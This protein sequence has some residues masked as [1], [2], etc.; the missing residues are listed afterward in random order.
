MKE[1]LEILSPVL[2]DDLAKDIIQHRRGLKC[3]LTARGA[4]ALLKQYEMTGNAVEAA[5]EHL[6]RGWQ[7]FKAEWM[8]K[9]KSFRDERNP[10]PLKTSANYGPAE[11]VSPPEP[12]SPE[13]AER[14]RQMVAKLRAEGVIGRTMQ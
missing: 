1:I 10:M 9:G 12:I 14:R 6:N 8:Q 11:I 13:E 5:E 3:P 2:G 4:K 7:G